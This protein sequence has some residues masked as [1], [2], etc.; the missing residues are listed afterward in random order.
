MTAITSPPVLEGVEWVRPRPPRSAYRSDVALALVLAVA[1]GASVAL[2]RI[3]GWGEGAP[4]WGSV[5]WVL[6]MSLPLAA[7]RRWHPSP[8][9]AAP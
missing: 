5:L 1:T 4:G 8:S 9:S 2:Y 7:R 3:T 6:A